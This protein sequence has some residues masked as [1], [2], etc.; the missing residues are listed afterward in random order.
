M[1]EITNIHEPIDYVDIL[2]TVDWMI[3]QKFF[4]TF[5]PDADINDLIIV[6]QDSTS[7]DSSKCAYCQYHDNPPFWVNLPG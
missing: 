1:S 5:G 6:I 7:G 2:E 4:A 3:E